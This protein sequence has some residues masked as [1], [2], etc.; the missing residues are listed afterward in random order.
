MAA[1]AADAVKLGSA[2]DKTRFGVKTDHKLFSSAWRS[3]QISAAWTFQKRIL[4][5]KFSTNAHIQGRIKKGFSKIYL[6][7]R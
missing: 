3:R 6:H 4:A 5:P 2:A 1:A 7:T